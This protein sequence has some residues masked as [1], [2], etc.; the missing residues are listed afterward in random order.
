VSHRTRAAG[1]VATAAVCAGLAAASAG[2]GDGEDAA[3]G[4]LRSVVVATKALPARRAL[5]RDAIAAGLEVRRIPEAFAAPDALANPAEAIGR[6]PAAPVPA[7]AYLVGSQLLS[8]RRPGDMASPELDAGRRPVEIAVAAAGP[9]ASEVGEL[10][11]VIVTGE[12]VAGSGGG[13]TYVAAAEVELLD[14]RPAEETDIASGPL[15]AGDAAIATLA[16]KRGQALR[17]IHAQS[18]AREVRLIGA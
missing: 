6:R 4:R 1:F 16:L 13:R 9:L 15:P 8:P 5:D 10:V 11:D 17:L 14:L 12:P 2:A 18:F 7:G 3:L